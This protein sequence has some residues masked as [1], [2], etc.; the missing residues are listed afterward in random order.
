MRLM[1]IAIEY[2]LTPLVEGLAP[3]DITDTFSKEAPRL[4]NWM[5]DCNITL[6][7]TPVGLIEL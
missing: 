2:S 6:T 7:H 1:E 5:I 3:V 4:I